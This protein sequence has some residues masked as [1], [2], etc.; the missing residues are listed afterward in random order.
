[1]NLCGPHS[2]KYSEGARI[3]DELKPSPKE[4]EYV[5]PKRTYSAFDGTGLDRALRGLYNGN[6]ADTL[7]ISGLTTD[8]CDRTHIRLGIYEAYLWSKNSNSL[9]P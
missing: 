7:I 9:T 5:I 3:I 1:M 2:M 6:G 4:S 8:I